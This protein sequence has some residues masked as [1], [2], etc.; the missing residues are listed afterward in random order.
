MAPAPI[1]KTAPASS[2]GI[3]QRL[4]VLEAL[5][6]EGNITPQEYEQMRQEILSS[7]WIVSAPLLWLAQINGH[8][9][10]D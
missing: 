3:A 9:E 2:A 1:A 7:V 4:D 10:A 8:Q 5:R 6:A